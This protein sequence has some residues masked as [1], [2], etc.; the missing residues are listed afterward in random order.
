[1]HWME[2]RK[3]MTLADELIY[4]LSRDARSIKRLWDKNWK[5]SS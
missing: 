1:M 5:A 3:A 2:E 4:L